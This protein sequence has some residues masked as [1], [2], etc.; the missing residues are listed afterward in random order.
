MLG[1]V[2]RTTMSCTSIQTHLLS[3][4]KDNMLF[5]GFRVYHFFV[6]ISSLTLTRRKYKYIFDIPQVFEY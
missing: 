1:Q 2:V 3:Y 5:V 4:V 6:N